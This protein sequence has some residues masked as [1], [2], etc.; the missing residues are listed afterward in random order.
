MTINILV[1]LE[2]PAFR[3]ISVI[4]I[5]HHVLS[6][7]G[8][9]VKVQL[10]YLEEKTQFSKALDA[11]D[12]ASILVAARNTGESSYLLFNKAKDLG[13]PI[14]YDID[15]FLWK[16]PDY[17][18]VEPGEE[19]EVDRFLKFADV[20]TTPSKKIKDYILKKF[21]KKEVL[22]HSNAGNLELPQDSGEQYLSAVLVK[23]DAFPAPEFESDFFNALR[24]AA[25]E[26]NKKIILYYFVPDAPTTP[27]DDP[28]LQ[29]IWVGFRYYRSYRELLHYFKP[30]LGFI[31]LR[32]ESFSDYKSVVKIAEYSYSN[33]LCLASDV[34]L[35][36]SIITDSDNGFLS[37][38]DYES[39]K[40]TFTKAFSL[41][42]EQRQKM[43]LRAQEQ[44]E[45]YFDLKSISH[46]F[47]NIILERALE[48]ED[49]FE[50]FVDEARAY[51]QSCF[52][53]AFR[54]K[55]ELMRIKKSYSYR[56]GNILMK[57][58]RFF[59]KLFH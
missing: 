34:E 6:L 53:Y 9:K 36:R 23:S 46:S 37:K 2:Q 10:Y 13:I 54:E 25:R 55:E 8:D 12:D 27:I 22:I 44:C 32:D 58:F 30:D 29:V 16:R 20:V 56:L 33:I 59:Y 3:P 19:K 49:G 21:P 7:M 14:L 42:E 18:N 47:G 57:P 39:W 5:T 31:L 26:K 41:S 51:D 17:S 45:K 24:D 50:N 11:L 43:I 52:S 15:D 28:Y 1:C 35:Y 48:R 4:R 40:R 38:N